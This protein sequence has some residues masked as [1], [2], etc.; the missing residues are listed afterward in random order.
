MTWIRDVLRNS[1]AG[2]AA[3]ALPADHEQP[4]A[5]LAPGVIVERRSVLWLPAATAAALLFGRQP[6]LRAGDGSGKGSEPA[7]RDVRLGWEEFLKE[8]LAVAGELSK[9]SSR[10][11]QDTYLQRL[12]ALAVRLKAA[13]DTKLYPFGRLDPKVEFAPSFRGVPF[14][15][16]QWRMHPKAIL[17]AHCHPHASVCTLGLEGEARLRNFEIEGSAPAFDSG[18]SDTFL[19]RETHSEIITPGRVNTVSTLRDNI[20]YFEASSEG[21]RGIDI[22]TMYGGDGSFSFVAFTPDRPKDPVRR[23]F[24]A[25]WTGMKL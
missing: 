13:P 23:V 12:A 16:V 21:A 2:R 7:R 25:S 14:V 10:P 19:M 24:E 15:I 22:T 8:C 18:S 17:P 6:R 3:D 20:H 4:G 5:E 11:G 1:A 9:D